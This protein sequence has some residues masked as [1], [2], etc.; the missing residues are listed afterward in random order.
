MV[1]TMS[2]EEFWRRVPEIV[3]REFGAYGLAR[4]LRLSGEGAGNYTRDQHQWQDEVTV[5]D[6]SGQCRNGYGHVAA[7][8]PVHI[9]PPRIAS[10][11][12][13]PSFPRE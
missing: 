4:F 10:L 3:G 5:Q 1:H 7:L 6:V 9:D 8:S 2:D 12:S 11:D 13:V